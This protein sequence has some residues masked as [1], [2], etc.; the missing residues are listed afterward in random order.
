[1]TR[2]FGTSQLSRA[3]GKA[4]GLPDFLVFGAM[5]AGTTSLHGLL[6]SLPNLSL[7]NMKETDFF[8]HSKNWGL[9]PEWYRGLFQPS[10]DVLKGEVNPNYSKRDVFPEVPDLVRDANPGVRLIYLVRDP[11]LRAISHYRHTWASTGDLPGSGPV[12]GSWDERHIIATSKYAWQ[13]EA[14]LAHFPAEQI[15]VL[16]FDALV[17]DTLS[18]VQAVARHI[19]A[20]LPRTVEV[21]SED[22]TSHEVARMPRWWHALRNTPAG[23]RARTLAP[24]RLVGAVKSQ[25]KA[26]EGSD[27]PGFSDAARA[28][29][30]DELRADAQRFRTLSG[31][32]FEHWSV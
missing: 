21:L 17:S 24:K 15:L 8:I 6:A 28:R 14:W 30:E 4:D 25:L 31:M 7:P 5:R 29:F 11:V 32:G 3:S 10:Q 2:Q 19:G 16:D 26:K 27:V 22:N 12:A 20:P 13:L 1:M 18:E 23:L 9:G